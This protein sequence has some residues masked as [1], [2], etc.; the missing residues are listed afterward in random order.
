MRYRHLSSLLKIFIVIDGRLVLRQQWY[1]SAIPCIIIL[2]TVLLTSLVGQ[3][4]N[5]VI[6]GLLR[7]VLLHFKER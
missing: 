6:M 3:G 4:I 1:I 2:L 7:D 5:D